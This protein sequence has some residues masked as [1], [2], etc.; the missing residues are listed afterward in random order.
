[1]LTC[2]GAGSA[3]V[4][5]ATTDGF[6]INEGTTSVNNFVFKYYG[7]GTVSRVV[8]SGDGLSFVSLDTNGGTWSFD[9]HGN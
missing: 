4:G 8:F 5:T 3:S 2:T 9:I 7:S 6:Y 1:V